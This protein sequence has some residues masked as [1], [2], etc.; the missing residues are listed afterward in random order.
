[1]RSCPL[2]TIGVDAGM[3]LKKRATMEGGAP[4]PRRLL[5]LCEN[6]Q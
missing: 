4:E 5:F 3:L 6:W 1:M 2:F